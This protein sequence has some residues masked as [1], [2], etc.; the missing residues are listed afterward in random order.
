MRSDVKGRSTPAISHLPVR[1]P[2]IDRQ[3]TY[4]CIDSD[5]EI[6]ENLINLH[7]ALRQVDF[8]N[9]IRKLDESRL[10]KR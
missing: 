7:L 4:M 2:L 10:Q 5:D 9:Q 3:E 6:T 8:L 1:A